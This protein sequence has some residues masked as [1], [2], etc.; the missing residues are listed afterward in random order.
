MIDEGKS[1]ARMSAIHRIS[2]LALL[3]LSGYMLVY[4]G[5]KFLAFTFAGFSHA[6]AGVAFALQLFPMLWLGM[7]GVWGCV[8]P[9]P[10]RHR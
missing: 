5:W 2:G 7:F 3:V 9:A 10:G 8:R 4:G 6:G 1:S